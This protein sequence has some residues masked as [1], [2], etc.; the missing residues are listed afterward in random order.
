MK[1]IAQN[2]NSNSLNNSASFLFMSDESFDEVVSPIFTNNNYTS[3]INILK[4][5]GKEKIEYETFADENITII[6]TIHKNSINNNI[7]IIKRKSFMSQ[8]L[9]IDDDSSSITI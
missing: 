6:H 4:N 1:Q 9:A 5:A 3:V 8:S 7:T 2:N